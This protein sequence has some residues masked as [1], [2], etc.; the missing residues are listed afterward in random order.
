MFVPQALGICLM[1]GN[2][3]E[4]KQIPSQKYPRHSWLENGSFL[5]VLHRL[6]RT[7]ATRHAFA[8]H[9]E[10]NKCIYI[11]TAVNFM[12]NDPLMPLQFIYVFK[13][14]SVTEAPACLPLLKQSFIKMKEHCFQTLQNSLNVVY[15]WLLHLTTTACHQPKKLNCKNRSCL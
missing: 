9:M 7:W 14:A 6:E 4:R 15:M 3:S 11:K 5:R 1:E 10:N 2:H 8:L 13:L 12:I